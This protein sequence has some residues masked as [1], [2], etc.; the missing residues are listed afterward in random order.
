MDGI[1]A[2]CDGLDDRLTVECFIDINQV[3]WD[4]LKASGSDSR[5]CPVVTYRADNDCVVWALGLVSQILMIGAVVV[6]EVRP[7]FYAPLVEAAM[8]RPNIYALGPVI[9]TRPE[10][11]V[12]LCAMLAPAPGGVGFDAHAAVWFNGVPF[13]ASAATPG[14][15][16][17]S[18]RRKLDLRGARV[19]VGGAI[20]GV[21]G[22]TFGPAATLV[23]FCGGVDEVRV[24]A[25]SRYADRISNSGV[26]GLLPAQRV[27]PWPNY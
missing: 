27:I 22:F 3:A 13:S 21:P 19:R 20:P 7:A 17:L 23:P 11:F 15:L 25:A 26:F 4:A 1:I 12:H 10:R 24:T 16:Y 14:D 5:F 8:R 6:R 2:G 9:V 18:A